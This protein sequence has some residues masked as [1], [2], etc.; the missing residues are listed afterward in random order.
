M[1]RC[2][3]WGARSSRSHQKGPSGRSVL[4]AELALRD[5]AALPVTWHATPLG[6]GLDAATVLVAPAPGLSGSKVATL[7]VPESFHIAEMDT[8]VTAATLRRWRRTARPITQQPA[9]YPAPGGLVC[10]AGAINVERAPV[11][12]RREL[13]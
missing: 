11:I 12:I 3:W 10:R 5:G 7:H 1:L 4:L 9:S 2:P 6:V 8:K 13:C